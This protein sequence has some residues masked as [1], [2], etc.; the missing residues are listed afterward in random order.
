MCKFMEIHHLYSDFSIDWREF[1]LDNNLM[2]HVDCDISRLTHH[3]P[4]FEAIAANIWPSLLHGKCGIGKTYFLMACMR[5]LM[6][7]GDI[8]K[9]N[10]RFFT[11]QQIENVLLE[12]RLNQAG[13][14]IFIN[15]FIDLKYLLIDELGYNKPL[16]FMRRFYY[17]LV[18]QRAQP[19]LFTL[20]TTNLEEAQIED[21]Y[22]ASVASRI[23]EFC[24]I[25]FEGRDQRGFDAS[26]YRV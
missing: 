18:E 10:F 2:K 1:C 16:P 25:H 17:E 9:T 6:A 23:K 21:F 8:N 15:K 13:Q 7:R 19:S 26:K 3:K 4:E 5:Y 11:G 24:T 22:G 20:I 12:Y 14:S